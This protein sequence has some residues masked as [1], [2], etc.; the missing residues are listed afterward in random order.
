MRVVSGMI[1]VGEP[2]PFDIYN[3]SGKLCLSRGVVLYTQSKVDRVLEARCYTTEHAEDYKLH[4]S[5]MG[6]HSPTEYIESLVVRLEVAYIN[7][8]TD[9]YNL[10]EEVRRIARELIEVLGQQPDICIGLIHLRSDLNHAIFRT[11]QNTVLAVLTA[12]RLRWGQGMVESIACASLT[13]NI[14]MYLLQLDL[15]H[16]TELSSDQRAQ[17]RQHPRQSSKL[18]M[19]LGVKDR[20]WIQTVAYHHE[21]MDGSGYPYAHYG[22]DIPLESRLLAVVDRYGSMVSPRR[23][24]RAGSIK[25]VMRYFL[26]NKQREYDQ[27]ISKVMIS[28]IGFYPPGTVVRLESGEIAV[29]TRRTRERLHP[30]VQAVWREDNSTYQRPLERHTTEKGFR[31]VSTAKHQDIERL[32][33]DLLWGEGAEGI[34]LFRDKVARV[35][36]IPNGDD[37]TLF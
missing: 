10:I 6:S 36:T 34:P 13:Q 27:Q 30:V 9:G 1:E 2:V 18:L 29:V 32:N 12:K 15:E 16:Q 24:R 26:S 11:M 31:I 8:I 14:G 3:E 22:K 25:E 17:I 5:V 20:S 23:Y 35:A 28:V 21:R 33:A 37:V 19:S 4:G 7:F